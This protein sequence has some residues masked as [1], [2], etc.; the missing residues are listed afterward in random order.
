M[1]RIGAL[2]LSAG[3]GGGGGGGAMRLPGLIEAIAAE[4]RALRWDAGA[5][6]YEVLN[7]PLF[8][9][10]CGS[11]SLRAGVAE[12]PPPAVGYGVGREAGAGSLESGGVRRAACCGRARCR[13]A[14]L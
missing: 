12:A 2:L 10:R 4:G 1:S 11:S 3:G 7:G 13:A 8:E 5:R 6:W 14:G 9:E